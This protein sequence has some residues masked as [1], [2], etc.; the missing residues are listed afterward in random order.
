M[1]LIRQIK[2]EW[3]KEKRSANRKLMMMTPLVFIMFSFLMTLLMG[4]APKGKSYLVAAAFNWYPL[5]ILPV[6]LT[7][8][9]TNIKGKEKTVNE[10]F[11]RSL[12]ID[13]SYQW[14]AKNMIV[15]FELLITLAFSG[16]LVLLLNGLLLN[17]TISFG[18]IV[19]ATA[20]LFLGSL[21]VVGISFVLNRFL[22]RIIVI[23]INF[24][25]SSAAALIA[26][27]GSWLLFAWCYNIRMMA[28]TLGLH[29][30]GTFLPAGS[31][32]LNTGSIGTG[33]LLSLIVYGLIVII[34]TALSK[35]RNGR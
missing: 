3:L 8:F 29:P 19:I 1:M 13:S 26:V 17:D 24:I 31:P 18:R 33:V 7:L 11:T 22:N 12:G 6:I 27:E 34:Q 4:T 25:L 16:L 15:I 9:V 32:L 20:C 14:M 23:L 10:V 30:N 28:P 35:R 21:P 2:A 5:I